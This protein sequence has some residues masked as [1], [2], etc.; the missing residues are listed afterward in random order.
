M[1]GTKKEATGKQP[2]SATASGMRAAVKHPS[3]GAIGDDPR[4]TPR[5]ERATIV[6]AFDPELLAKELEAQG[7]LR[8]LA[9]TATHDQTDRPTITPPFDPSSYARVV[10]DHV[11]SQRDP[12]DTPRTI[13]A[14]TPAL[15]LGLGD[16][17]VASQ[18]TG[19]IGRAMY[20][21]Y[22]Q[23]DYPEAL[24]LAERVL[25][26]EPDHALA[27]LVADGC[28]ERLEPPATSDLPRLL[29]S[30]VVR[31]R[32]PAHEVVGLIGSARGSSD[33]TS[34]LVVGHVDGVC[35]VSMLA[36]LAG[37]PRPDALDRLHALLEL[38][39][40]EVVNG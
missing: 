13:T 5:R 11:E 9:A 16:D 22:L 37:I 6:P 21:S 3:N 12:H 40:L 32:R 24:V 31:L 35:D 2:E 33:L 10:D 15:G 1:A 18:T 4:P 25:E 17:E 39:L 23:S 14:V 20:G 26:R 27:R 7:D 38:G 19:S 8:E 29:P 30:S 28:R 34:Q 36:A